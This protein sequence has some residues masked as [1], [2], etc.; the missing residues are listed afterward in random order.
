MATRL[1]LGLALLNLVFLFGELAINVLGVA[2][3]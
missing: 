3:S 2:L 1:L